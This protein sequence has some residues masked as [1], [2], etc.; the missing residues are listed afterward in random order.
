MICNHLADENMSREDAIDDLVSRL[1]DLTKPAREL[2]LGAVVV[3]LDMAMLDA[4]K[5]A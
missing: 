2:E 1:A 5:R 4:I 3:L